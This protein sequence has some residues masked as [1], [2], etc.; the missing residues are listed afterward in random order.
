ME[1]VAFVWFLSL[2]FGS[3]LLIGYAETH[4]AVTNKE[5]SPVVSV[6]AGPSEQEWKGNESSSVRVY[7]DRT[8]QTK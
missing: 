3:G 2:L 8:G 4:K 7:W 5:Q 1:T 6:D